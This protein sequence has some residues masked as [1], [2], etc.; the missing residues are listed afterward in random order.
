VHQGI[1]SGIAQSTTAN[2]KF[3]AKIGILLLRDTLLVSISCNNKLDGGKK[4][5]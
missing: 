4:N 2:L 1:P 5:A 3:E